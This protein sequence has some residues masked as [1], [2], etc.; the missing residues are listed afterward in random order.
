MKRQDHRIDIGQAEVWTTIHLRD[1][2]ES[3]DGTLVRGTWTHTSNSYK[4]EKISFTSS[5]PDSLVW[6]WRGPHHAGNLVIGVK[7]TSD[8]SH[9]TR[10]DFFSQILINLF[11]AKRGTTGKFE[12]LVFGHGWLKYRSSNG[13][14]F[15]GFITWYPLGYE[16]G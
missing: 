10:T 7:D 2:E 16:R 4:N 9:K 5:H 13:D 3:E 1:K 12:V 14:F 15:P 6:E 11:F 8:S